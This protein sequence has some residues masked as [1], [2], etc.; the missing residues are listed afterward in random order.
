MD[1]FVS[2]SGD[3]LYFSSDRPL[4]NS[5]KSEPTVDTNTWFAPLEG[6]RWGTPV[7]AGVGINSAADET[8][9]SESATGQVVFARFGE[10]RGRE[11]PTSI[12]S[13]Q[14]DGVGFSNLRQV[15]TSPASLRLSNPAISPDGK[16]IVATGRV[17]GNPQLFFSQKR[18]NGQWQK[19]RLL[20]GPINQTQSGQFAPYITNDGRTLYFS[21]N[22]PAQGVG[23]DNIYSFPLPDPIIGR[24]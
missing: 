1:P 6:S 9:F 18:A 5:L 8:F 2:R 20:P 4:P 10:G 24:H 16:L 19:F 7:F 22:R 14:R 21:S 17:G 15:I 23:E 11:R 12:M 3:R 13:A